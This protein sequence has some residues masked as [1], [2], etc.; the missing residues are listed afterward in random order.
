MLVCTRR[1]RGTHPCH[2]TTRRESPGEW[3]SGGLLPTRFDIASPA[4][5]PLRALLGRVISF[6]FACGAIACWASEPPASPCQGPVLSNGSFEEPPE[7]GE[8]R[9]PFWYLGFADEPLPPSAGSWTLDATIATEGGHSLRL[10]PDDGI[11]VSQVLHLPGGLLEGRTISA[12]VWIRHEDTDEMPVVLVLAVNP[13]LPLI[14]PLLGPGFAGG[15][16]LVADG[17][18]GVWKHYTGSLTAVGPSSFVLVYLSAPGSRGSVWFDGIEVDADPWNPGPGPDPHDIEPPFE[19][20]SFDLG[21]TSEGPMDMSELG[22]SCLFETAA[23]SAELLNV[24]F[25]VR[26]CKLGG[27]TCDSDPIHALDLDTVRRARE[28]GMKVAL[29]F[30][31]TH[32]K[33]EDAGSI[34][35]LNPLPDGSSPGSLLDQ[36]VRRALADELLW[37]VDKARPDYL[38]IGIEVDIFYERHPE[39][40]DAF[41]AMEREVYETVKMHDPGIHVTCYHR[42]SWSVNEHGQLRAEAAA[43]WRDLLAGI[44][45]IAYSIYPNTAFPGV[46]VSAY[47]A[48][49][50]AR[51]ADIAPELPVLVPEFGMAG[52]GSS[53]YSE[54]EQAEVLEVMLDEL[55]TV[56][57]VALIWFQI[58]D[59][60]YLEAPPWASEAFDHIGMLD[61]SGTPKTSLALWQKVHDLP[62]SSAPPRRPQGRVGAP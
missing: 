54:A 2:H 10:E 1:S 15:F 46:P 41:V 20:R 30:D 45:S 48:G 32:G 37:L 4:T 42:A 50:F 8:Q 22:F 43:V 9:P 47:P 61:L 28:H 3:R 26:W 36:P 13:R 58:Y 16:L 14:D 21:F 44:D 5:P 23:Q 38:L 24:F 34:G 11:S 39:Q 31:F 12:G 51:P 40:W 59:R 6:V 18:E 49:Y 56:D 7:P 17:E 53:A 62:R 19:H 35:D 52:G 27:D 25:A 29:T 60:L 55:A 57:P 33:P